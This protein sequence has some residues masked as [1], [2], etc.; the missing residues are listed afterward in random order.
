MVWKATVP[1][2]KTMLR[3]ILDF[4][5][6]MLIFNLASPNPDRQEGASIALGELVRNTGDLALPVVIKQL[7][8]AI[9]DVDDTVKRQG[10]CF[11]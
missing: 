2:T 10:V 5:M 9:A 3:R 11:G 8:A 6:D 7:K 1:K 4:L